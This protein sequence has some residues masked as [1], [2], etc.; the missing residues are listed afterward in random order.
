MDLSY[1]N[2]DVRCFLKHAA[3]G[4]FCTFEVQNKTNMG[5]MNATDKVF[6]NSFVIGFPI[7]LILRLKEKKK[8]KNI[9]SL[10]TASILTL[11]LKQVSM[12]VCLLIITLL[13]FQAAMFFSF[14]WNRYGS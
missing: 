6:S 7:F 5:L 3:G 1:L 12:K 9:I 8:E 4:N 11:P 13:H 2:D 14:I 10:M